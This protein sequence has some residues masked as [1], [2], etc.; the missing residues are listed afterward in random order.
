MSYIYDTWAS[1]SRRLWRFR[2]TMAD[3]VRI[4][5]TMAGPLYCHR[6][7]GVGSDMPRC[8]WR[9]VTTA[10]S[11]QR[12]LG[13]RSSESTRSAIASR[14]ELAR[15][16]SIPRLLRFQSKVP[17]RRRGIA[18]RSRREESRLCLAT[19][20]VEMTA[21]CQN[22]AWWQAMGATWE[23]GS[24]HDPGRAL[25]GRQRP[26]RCNWRR[27]FVVLEKT[28]NYLPALE[29]ALESGSGFHGDN[30]RRGGCSHPMEHRTGTLAVVTVRSPSWD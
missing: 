25:G 3:S 2:S 16:W 24:F 26:I 17:S 4:G 14:A 7:A 21:S 5:R 20:F 28:R 6:C 13:R 11:L 10:A 18:A 12:L 15:G 19:D 23:P 30:D 9:S 22:P 29:I 8:A 27:G 1:V